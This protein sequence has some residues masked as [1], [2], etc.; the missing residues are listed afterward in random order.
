MSDACC[1]GDSAPTVMGQPDEPQA[2]FWALRAVQAAAVS[3]TLLAAGLVAGWSGA[4]PVSVALLVAALLVGGATF[5]P[6]SLRGLLAG[7]L[8]VGTL[9]TIAAIGAVLLG[10]IG[11]AAGLAFLFSISEA[12]ESYSLDRSRRSLRALLSLVPERATVLRSG[13]EADVAPSELDLGDVLV[14]R[15][16]ERIATDGTVRTGR[17]TLDVSAITGE[18]VPVETGPGHPVYAGSINGGGVLEVEVTARAEAN[19]LARIVHIV[20][21][22][23][24]RKGSSQRLA[25]RIARPLVPGVMVLAAGIAVVGS[26]LGDPAVWI[27]RA[28][29]VLVAAAPCAFA[30]SVPVT[31]FAAIGA[32]SRSGILVKGGAALEALGRIRTV[33]LDKTGTLTRNDPAVIDVVTAPGASREQVLDVAAAL[34]ARSEHPLAAAILHATPVH[35]SAND[36][37][38]V[39]GSGLT[40]TL[41][42]RAARLGRP[43]FIEPGPLL[44]RVAAL[45]SAGATVVLVELDGVL[46]GAVAVRDELRPEA[47]ATVA[48][49]RDAGLDV[50]MLTGDNPLTAAALARQAGVAD[51]HADLR[52]ED[53]ARIVG[54]LRARRPVAMVGD[55]INDAPALATADS[56][57]AMGA[58][59]TDVAIEAADVA[60][61]G[62]DLRHLP[63]A[64]LHARRARA[65]MI[66]NLA[67]SGL[68]L[69]TLVPL[70]AF[71]VLGL[72]AVV[73]SHE[74]AEVL[75]IANGVRAGRRG[76]LTLPED[77]ARPAAAVDVV[78]EPQ[79]CADG[80]C[81]PTPAPIAA[82]RQ[83]R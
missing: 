59:G 29:V 8:G 52:P 81:G 80:C 44:D 47:P 23:Q 50:V 53:K 79:P 69:L 63:A 60:L 17:S 66:Q 40:G 55:G 67:M 48:A 1:G 19:S 58:M 9:M 16:G 24:E 26:L 37:E 62:E 36:V 14:V 12:L 35:G 5:V 73:A 72:A 68:I 65:I 64:L 46:L 3:G 38:A 6:Q 82:E 7:R 49:L 25:E 30:I 57:I 11:E 27:E 32:A 51:V 43:G 41:D 28:L 76:R 75:V 54:E 77:T 74:L 21:E 4:G 61:M 31:V 70:A 18:S 34:E 42:G 78:V 2:K 13:V 83:A 10:E 20:E 39:P 45:Q 22:A 33:A 71:G 15:P 56:G